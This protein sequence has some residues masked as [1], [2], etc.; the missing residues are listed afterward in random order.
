MKFN[1]IDYMEN[2]CLLHDVLYIEFAVENRLKNTIRSVK[3][4]AINLEMDIQ[5][6]S[7]KHFF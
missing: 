1:S 4:V 3:L 5:P 2:G 6:V 7:A